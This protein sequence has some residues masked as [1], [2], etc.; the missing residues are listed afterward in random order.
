MESVVRDE[1]ARWQRQ[2][3]VLEAAE[4]EKTFEEG[5]A[6]ADEEIAAAEDGEESEQ[7]L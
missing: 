3:E 6:N 5:Y 1:K 7:S 2:G 4:A